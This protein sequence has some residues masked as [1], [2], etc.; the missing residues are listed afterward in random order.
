MSSALLWILLPVSFGAALLLYRRQ[1]SI[2]LIAAASACLLLSW[3]AWQLPIDVVLQLGPF[4][5]E[6]APSFVLFGRSFTLTDAQAPLLA[7]IYLLQTIWILGAQLAR[8]GK[9]F[10]PISLMC[11]GL[12]VAALAVEPFLYAAL[13]IAVAAMLQIPL[14]APAGARGLGVLRFLKF[15]VFAVPFILFTGWIL[16][17][18]EASPGNLNLAV[19]AGLLL[20]LGF[21]FLL[22]LFPFH[23]WLPMLASESHP[24]VIGFLA[25]FLPSVG[26]I[27]GLG[28]FDR[29]SWLRDSLFAYP[30]LL[31]AGGLTALLAGLWAARENH[32]GRTLGYAAM[33]CIGLGLQ[34]LGLGDQSVQTFFALLLPQAFALWGWAT[35]LSLTTSADV[36]SSDLIAWRVRA[37]TQPLAFAALLV[38]V[39][40]LGG[41]PLLGSF[42]SRLA[43]LDGVVAVSPWAALASLIGSLGLLAAGVRIVFVTFI[44]SNV[45]KRR[46]VEEVEPAASPLTS[47]LSSPYVW[48]FAAVVILSLLGFGLFPRIFL[49]SVPDLAAMFSQLSP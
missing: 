27:F 28:F 43:L 46:W 4:S 49:A 38:A 35:A 33:F 12:L 17:G 37:R 15:Q 29:Y 22:A 47:D 26:L 19:R 21:A 40:S 32:T 14:L 42:P 16:S 20:A 3:A 24:Y 39:F 48:I 44:G 13:L 41:L 5:V 45:D 2:P 25:F 7:L 6:I 1:D 23:S 30:L 9:L 18:V 10:V 11:V 34:A 36:P 31:L 8:P